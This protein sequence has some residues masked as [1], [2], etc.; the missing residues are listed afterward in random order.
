[1][2]KASHIL[3]E[4]ITQKNVFYPLTIG[5]CYILSFKFN[6]GVPECHACIQNDL[7]KLTS[8]DPFQFPIITSTLSATFTH[9]LKTRWVHLTL[10]LWACVP[11]LLL[12]HWQPPRVCIPEENWLSLLHQSLIASCSS[13][14]GRISWAPPYCMLRLWLSRSGS[15]LVAWRHSC[16][17]RMPAMAL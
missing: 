4:F 8:F 2:V 12:V 6:F 14:R 3:T 5:I 16:C 15:G 9:F 11:Y 1:M 17:K 10:P 13:G 7:T